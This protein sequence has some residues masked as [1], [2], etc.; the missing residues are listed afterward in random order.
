[1]LFGPDVDDLAKVRRLFRRKRDGFLE[2]RLSDG[3]SKNFETEKVIHLF[4]VVDGRSVSNK[5]SDPSL[6]F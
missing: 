2:P 6:F 4:S 3:K 1:L 5:L